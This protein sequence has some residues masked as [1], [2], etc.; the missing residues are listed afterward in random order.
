M[1]ET[2]ERVNN[3]QRVL[4]YAFDP[5]V[6]VLFQCSGDSTFFS[7]QQE[8]TFYFGEVGTPTINKLSGGEIVSENLCDVIGNEIAAFRAAAD[9]VESLE[10]VGVAEVNCVKYYPKWWKTEE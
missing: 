8:G 1:T 6:E 7:W 4:A 9:A 2:Q 3:I 5:M 10:V